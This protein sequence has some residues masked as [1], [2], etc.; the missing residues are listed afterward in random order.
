M[1]AI[2]RL[3]GGVAHDFNNLLTVIAGYAELLLD[4]LD[5]RP[6][7]RRWSRS[8]A[9]PARRAALTRQLLAFSRQQVLQPRVLDLNEIVARHGG[10]AA[11]AHRR[12]RRARRSASPPTSSLVEADP[13]Q[14][15]Q[16]IL[17]LAVNAR[18]AMP[19][20]GALTIETANV[21][22]DE[23]QVSAARRGD[24]RARTSLLA[25]SDTGIGMDEARPRAPFEPFFTTKDA[26]KGT[27]LGL[28]TVLRHRQAERR[29]HL[30]LQRA[31]ARH[32][33]QDLPAGGGRRARRAQLAVEPD[34]ARGAETILLVEDDD[35]VR[36]SCG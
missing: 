1:E 36:D 27:G 2:G 25:V 23:Q 34:S 7:A 16:V 19:G 10:D 18:D 21:E 8:R 24:R 11:P 20:G 6:G 13:G 28:A 17:N 14:I 32:D 3:A 35:G 5:R 26:G 29:R 9:P 4:A 31:G 22:L 33:L 12:G 15:E 30:R